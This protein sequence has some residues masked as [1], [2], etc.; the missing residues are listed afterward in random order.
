MPIRTNRG[1]AA[2]YR[3]LWGAPLRSPKHLIVTVAI[4]VA[5][6]TGIGFL[7][8]KVVPGVEKLGGPG[9]M[10]TSTTESAGELGTSPASPTTSYSE[11]RITTE[12]LTPSSAPPSP[13]AIRIAEKWAQAWVDHP[14]GTSQKEW[15][16]GLAPYTTEEYLGVMESV[17]PANVPAEKV[18]GKPT[19]VAS[20]TSSVDVDIATDGPT[21]RLTVVKTDQGWR[22][23][24]YGEAG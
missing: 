10:A 2:V 11:T 5:L 6:L 16:K 24:N 12:P 21:I 14:K 23:A 19:V 3:R 18:T 8:P 15:L 22:V 17:D 9:G 7:L 13:E 1:R 4:V 20:H